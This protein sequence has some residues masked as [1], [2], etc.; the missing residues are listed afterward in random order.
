MS[1]LQWIRRKSGIDT[2]AA[3]Y[4]YGH[5]PVLG[6]TSERKHAERWVNSTC[7][8]CSVG[9]GMQLGVREGKVVSVRGNPEHP[10]NRGKL[11]PKGLAEH[12]AIDAEGRALYPLLRTS[13]GLNRVSW[14]E[15]VGTMV[16]QF[17]AVQRKFGP[18]SV[19]VISTGQLVTE[20]FYTLGKLVQLGLG[21]R[22]YD[23]NTTLCMST[24]VAGYKRSFGSDGPPGA[25]EDL[26]LSDLVLL[27]GAN[28]AEN[29]PILCSR[30]EANTNKKLIV[31][32]PRVTKTAMMADVY[33]PI[34]PRADLA[35]INGMLRIV[36]DEGLYDKDYVERHTTGFDEL[37]ASLEPYSLEYV[38][39]ISGLDAEQIRRTAHLYAA[40]KAPFIGWT[41]GVN[42]STKGTETVNA[43]NNLALITGNVGR[44]GASP[45]SITGQCNAMGTREAGFASGLP[46]YRSFESAEHRDELARIWNIDVGRIPAKRGLAYPDIIEAAVAGKIRALWIIGTNPLVSFPNVDVLKQGFE[47]LE[48]LVVQDGFHPTPTTEL[49]DLVLPAAI[50]G[51]K[52]GTYTNSERR[53]S[54]VNPAVRP[55]GEARSDFDIFLAVAEELGC[56]G[57]L[58]P[59]WT[60]PV[61]AFEEWRRVSAGRLCDYSEMTYELI[62]RCGG[63]QWPLGS[64]TQGD[65]RATRRLYGSGAFPTSDGRAR[66]IATRW[67]PFPEQPNAD[68]PLVLNTGRTVEHWHTRTK[69]G[70]IS[71]LQ[72]MSPRAW[73]EMNPADAR[74]LN[75]KPHDRVE[76]ISARGRVSKVELRVTEIIAPGQVFLPFHFAESNANQVT[77]SAFDPISREPNFKQCA[78]RVEKSPT[79]S[80]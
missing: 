14:N 59:H 9:C 12:Y 49:A 17:R 23:G 78:V 41:M 8:Y 39:K 30:L 66:L 26:E 46:G 20:E 51:E 74:Q 40:A 79:A 35:L 5:D 56:R 68:F 16:A 80:A 3:K 60:E 47:N 65:A 13:I 43:I 44:A 48:F 7:G 54:K 22:N 70:S 11:C 38:S 27:I 76:I 53:V 71:I 29:H 73:L 45:F 4:T 34:R 69:T 64:E 77:Q 67:A 18:D 36:I 24:A 57:E 28:I 75:L 31:V 52:E 50:W 55:P 63:I 72:E 19:G 32:D 33:L 58:F 21:T 1:V 15:A 61:D 37:R 42:H 6:Y 25:Y 10:V 62:E 2:Q